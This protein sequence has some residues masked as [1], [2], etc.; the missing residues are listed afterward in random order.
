V[1]FQD[2]KLFQ[3]VRL[4]QHL[5]L[6]RQEEYMEV[7]EG[8]L[9]RGLLLLRRQEE[10]MEVAEGLLSRGLLLRRQ[11]EVSWEDHLLI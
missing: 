5:L 3:G 6:R 7:A 2:W 4:N 8:L 1:L 10:Y 9:S 11:E